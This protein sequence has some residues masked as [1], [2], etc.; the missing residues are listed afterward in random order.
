LIDC[1]SKAFES[2]TDT[3]RQ[4]R[5]YICVG[6]VSGSHGIAGEV[7]ID[8]YTDTPEFFTGFRRLRV[9]NRFISV[10]S[11]RVHNGRALVLF[12]GFSTRDEADTI[13]GAEV[14]AA[15]E[16]IRLEKGEHLIADIIGY[17]AVDADTGEVFG[18][19][20]DYLD[21]PGHAV[22]ITMSKTGEKLIPA[23][24]EFVRRIDAVGRSVHFHLIEGL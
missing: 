13:K 2:E 9:N 3:Q 20:S 19:V 17:A 1:S 8:T 23:A 18:T 12:Q 10:I 11:A 21:L 22:W 24:P 5:Q 4:L 7:K 15:R 16:D 6:R 14:Y